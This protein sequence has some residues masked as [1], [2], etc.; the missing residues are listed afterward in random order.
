MAFLSL[1]QITVPVAASE[2]GEEF[3]SKGGLSESIGGSFING[4]IGRRKQFRITTTPMSLESA[5][6]LSAI[7]EGSGH[8][9]PLYNGLDGAT[10]INATPGYYQIYFDFSGDAPYA[11]SSGVLNC[12]TDGVTATDFA[13][14]TYGMFSFDAQFEDDRWTAIWH[15]S[16]GLGTWNSMART[17]LGVGYMNGARNDHVGTCGSSDFDPASLIAV[18]SSRGVF[19]F[20][21]AN[22][23]LV[24]GAPKIDMSWIEL[25]P[26]VLTTSQMEILTEGPITPAYFW[27]PFEKPFVTVRG[28]ILQLES[29]NA[30]DSER[31]ACLGTVLDFSYVP[32]YINGDFKPNAVQISF[33]LTEYEEAYGNHV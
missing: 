18:T 12:L 24:N 23:L 15:E 10:G 27:P 17:S 16:E 14:L 3:T 31:M 20:Y 8:T 33:T 32:C 4:K 1:N 21:V 19:K 6:G 5:L 11:T 25:I 26:E 13:I 7:I 22:N 2:A 29:P 28:D 9:V 30:R